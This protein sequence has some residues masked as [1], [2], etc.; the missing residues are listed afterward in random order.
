MTEQDL[1]AYAKTFPSQGGVEI[2]P[3][4]E[5]YAAQVPPGSSIV[6]VGCWLGGGTAHLALGAMKS[7]APIVTYDR[8]FCPGDEEQGK[9]ARYGIKLTHGEDTLPRV[10]ESL[11]PFGVAIDYRKGSW[12][13]FDWDKKPIGLYVDDLTK[14][15]FLWGEAMK[16]FLPSF[17]PEK[18][19]LFLQDYHFD[20]EA[21][22][23]YAAQK[24]YMAANEKRFE[25]VEDRLAGTTCALFRF[26]G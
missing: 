16:A 15:E 24:R 1:R 14:N 26:V 11:K 5:K 19:H 8:F 9:A 12:R 23:V 18:T 20:E 6:E 3:W 25:L 4:L 13:K 7:G 22:P 21:G 17:I 2:G 10:R